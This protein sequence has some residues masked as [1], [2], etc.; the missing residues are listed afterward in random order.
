MDRQSENKIGISVSARD[1]RKSYGADEILKGLTFDIQP[2]EIFVI[3]GASGSGKSTLLRQLMGLE[4]VDSGEI[5]IN[6]QSLKPNETMDHVRMAMV[7][8]SGALLN[9]LNVEE[10]VGIYLSEHQLA[11]PEEIQQIVAD[12]LSAV[13]LTGTEKRS[14]S[15]LSGGMK[16]RVA[17]ARALVIDP[18]LILYDEPTSELDPATAATIGSEIYTLNQKSGTT[19]VVVTHDRDLAFGIAHRIA[20]MHEG[21]ILDIGSPEKIRSSKIPEINHFINIDFKAPARNPS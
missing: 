3:M 9:S 1:V 2:G 20:I 18:Q 16:K 21:Q 8:Q 6:D 7:F 17:I 13:G 10:N 4:F 15:E 5:F 12:K 14:I 19:S 11:P